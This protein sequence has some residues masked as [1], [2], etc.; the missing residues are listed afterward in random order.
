MGGLEEVEIVRVWSGAARKRLVSL[1]GSLPQ[2]YY[3]FGK[4]GEYREVPLSRLEEALKLRG[5]TRARVD[6][7]QLL[8]YWT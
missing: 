4:P 3:V 7:D 6:R 1:L 2:G 8:G 5:I